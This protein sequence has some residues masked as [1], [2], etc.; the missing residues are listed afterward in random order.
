LAERIQK[1]LA[2]AGHGSRRKVETWIREGRLTIDGR[3]AEL[4]DH[5]EG[6]EKIALDGRLLSMKGIAQ[7]HRH[8]IYNKPADEVTS[9]E[10]PDGRKLVFDSLPRL[11]GARWVAV[12]RLDLATTG[13]LIFTTDGALANAL[14]HPSA[15]ILRKYAVRVHGDPGAADLQA[16]RKGVALLDGPAH[17]DSIEPGG[18]EGANRWF[19]VTLSEG[20][21]REVR[22][23]WE[24]VGYEV[25][26]LIRTAYGPVQLPRN[27]RRGKYQNLT[28]AQVRALYL[29][30]GLTER[31][32]SRR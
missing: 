29:A 31:Q 23:L 5:I 20:R 7:Q 3:P 8:I 4:G 14:M 27:L 32:N 11:K 2:A 13:L 30:A 10:D 24:A 18:G 21:N 25:S 19:N 28:T 17:F 15:E 22:R 1:I 12:G 26:R 9:R 6:T 16:L